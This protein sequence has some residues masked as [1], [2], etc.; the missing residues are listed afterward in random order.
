MFLKGQLHFHRKV[1]PGGGVPAV[2]WLTWFV[3]DTIP[4]VVTD[5]ASGSDAEEAFG[6]D[7][8]DIPGT[9]EKDMFK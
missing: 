5:E 4:D 1:L 8:V 7:G 3:P 6:R 9:F 2:A